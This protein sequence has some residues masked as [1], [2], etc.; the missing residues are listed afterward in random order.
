MQKINRLLVAV[1]LVAGLS[2]CANTNDV[3]KAGESGKGMSKVYPV[4]VEQAWNISKTVFR[5]EGTDAIEEHKKDG[6]MVTSSGMTFGS[7]GTV[8]GAWVKSVGNNKTKVTVVSKRR[9]KTDPFTTMRP[10]TFHK[11]FE[12]ALAYVK[13]GKPLPKTAPK[14]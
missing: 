13:L 4:S 7:Y 10:K 6:Y 3:V 5:W 8:M 9:I 12:Q 11:R 2:A 14:N 1:L